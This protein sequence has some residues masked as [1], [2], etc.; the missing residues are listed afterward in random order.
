MDSLNVPVQVAHHNTK[1]K[2][3]PA[4]N[5]NTKVLTRADS[6]S[7]KAVTDGHG[8]N[9]T[10]KD[11]TNIIRVSYGHFIECS[12][13]FHCKKS[14]YSKFAKIMGISLKRSLKCISQSSNNLS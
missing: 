13:W 1:R 10:C 12:A 2:T 8:I 6:A 4:E 14:T 11:F 9:I 7:P 3:R 5:S